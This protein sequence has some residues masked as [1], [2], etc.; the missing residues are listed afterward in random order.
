[1]HK[2]ALPRA[3]TQE[4]LAAILSMLENV[5]LLTS[6]L[7]GNL[8]QVIFLV[9]SFFYFLQIILDNSPF[10]LVLNIAGQIFLP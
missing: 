5:S 4:V 8:A 2:R 6:C 7:N 10:S 9:H 1:M 3:G